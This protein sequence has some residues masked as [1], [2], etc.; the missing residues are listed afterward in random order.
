[1]SPTLNADIYI[2]SNT[3]AWHVLV[4][5]KKSAYSLQTLSVSF[6]TCR[7]CVLEKAFGLAGDY[8]QA[9]Y[10][11]AQPVGGVGC[12]ANLAITIALILRMGGT[13][14]ALGTSMF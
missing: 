14:R 1:M 9:M 7:Q 2:G 10:T 5:F 11:M 8:T 6:S 4:K 3:I 13:K 12:P